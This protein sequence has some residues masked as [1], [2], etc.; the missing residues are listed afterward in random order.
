MTNQEK[1]R[2]LLRYQ[3]IDDEIA[4][5]IEE[6]AVWRERATKI[7]AS[8][9]GTKGGGSE[10]RTMENA[11]IKCAQISTEID[12]KISEAAAARREIRSCINRV[13]DPRFRRLLRLHYISGLTFEEVAE[14]MHYSC[15]WILKLHGQAL[16][17]LPA[18]EDMVVHVDP[19]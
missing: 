9:G 6:R 7:T 1:K 10:Q 3:D 4:A 8:T 18:K 14:R 2:Y 11:A 15:R 13:R 12:R 5:L 19:W 17:D 16:A